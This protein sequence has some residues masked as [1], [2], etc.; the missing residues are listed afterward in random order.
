VDHEDVAAARP[1]DRRA[2]A[3]GHQ[4]LES[5]GLAR[6]D[7]DQVDVLRVGDGLDGRCGLALG[8]DVRGVEP[9][10]GEVGL[11]ASSQANG[12]WGPG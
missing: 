8:R 7:D 5:A 6:S 11:A 12:P 10:P 3:R 1:G 9:A 2:H 4:P